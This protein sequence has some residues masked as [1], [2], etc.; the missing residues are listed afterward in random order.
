MY[1][2]VSSNAKAKILSYHCQKALTW[3]FLASS[4]LQQSNFD[5]LCSK[6]K[7]Q[8]QSIPYIAGYQ[9]ITNHKVAS[10][11]MSSVSN[12]SSSGLIG[13]S[14]CDLALLSQKVYWFI[15]LLFACNRLL[16]CFKIVFQFFP[17][18][19]LYQHLYAICMNLFINSVNAE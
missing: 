8:S 12:S 13:S 14:Q 10:N 16:R 17:S 18:P 1:F 15:F 5:Y 7:G 4:H 19:S 6:S 2:A 3:R 9:C 11:L